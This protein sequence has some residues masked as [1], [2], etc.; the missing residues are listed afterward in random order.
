[1]AIALAVVERDFS[2]NAAAPALS[3]G[4]PLYGLSTVVLG[5]GKEEQNSR[6]ARSHWHKADIT[7]VLINVR[8]WG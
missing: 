1:M 6:C 5:L 7:A 4:N 2:Q 3:R 8:F